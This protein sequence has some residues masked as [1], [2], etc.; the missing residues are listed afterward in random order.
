MKRITCNLIFF[1]SISKDSLLPYL[2]VLDTISDILNIQPFIEGY[3]DD[4]VN[5]YSQAPLTKYQEYLRKGSN[6]LYDH[7][8]PNHGETVIERI[9]YTGQGENHASLPKKYQ[10]NGG[11]PN[12]YERLHL[13]KPAIL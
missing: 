3:S 11:Y 1:F 2:N 8:A 12:I 4:L 13:N 7:F 9:S 10:L 6:K 5:I